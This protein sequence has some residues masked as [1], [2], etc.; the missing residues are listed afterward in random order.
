MKNFKVLPFVLSLILLFGVV[1]PAMANSQDA[2]S[3]QLNFT[4]PVSYEFGTLDSSTPLQDEYIVNDRESLE[5][6][7]ES[8]NIEVPEGYEL[9]SVTTT[10]V[11]D[12][13]AIK[14]FKEEQSSVQ[15][16]PGDDI[17]TPMTTYWVKSIENVRTLGERFYADTPLYSDW[18][19]GPLPKGFTYTLSDT[20]N[21][22]YKSELG[23][24]A[25]DISIKVGFDVAKGHAISRNATTDPVASGK[26]LNVKIYTNY[27]VKEFD[28]VRRLYMG[29]LEIPNMK[30]TYQGSAWKPIGY[31][32][33]QYHYNS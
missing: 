30:E 20:V 17:V 23:M 27:L 10:V 12:D 15:K 11:Y 28:E 9:S 6:I 24:S 29:G 21:A 18:L 26:R 16:N 8:E 4:G 31:I 32:L 25:S 19:D 1:S 2:P 7:I 14:S 33:R 22:G 13:A 5:Q 3:D